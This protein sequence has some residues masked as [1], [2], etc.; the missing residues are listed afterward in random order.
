MAAPAFT[1]DEYK[2]ITAGA[3]ADTTAPEVRL[4]TPYK[5]NYIA[6]GG[7]RAYFKVFLVKGIEY[8]IFFECNKTLV[9]FLADNASL[10]YWKPSDIGGDTTYSDGTNEDVAPYSLPYDYKLNEFVD[11]DWLGGRRYKFTP[12]ETG[13]HIFGS[14]FTIPC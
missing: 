3:T 5:T 4:N 6:N 8:T 11:P 7:Y 12:D 14:F 13:Y 9:D 1:I 2:A 10:L